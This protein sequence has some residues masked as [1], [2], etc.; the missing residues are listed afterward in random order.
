MQLETEGL[1]LPDGHRLSLCLFL[2]C[3]TALLEMSI[4]WNLGSKGNTESILALVV[5]T[6]QQWSFYLGL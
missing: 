4:R 2:P 3:R 6:G 1:H 5:S